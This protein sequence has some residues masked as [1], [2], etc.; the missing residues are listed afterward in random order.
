MKETVISFS[1]HRKLGNKVLA[2]EVFLVTIIRHLIETHDKVTF[3]FGGALGVDTMASEIA[4]KL[5]DE[6]PHKDVQVHLYLPCVGFES[7][8][9][10]RDRQVLY[11]QMEKA[12]FWKYVDQRN[13]IAPYQLMNRNKAMVNDS[14]G[15]VAVWNGSKSGTSNCVQY[16]KQ[17]ARHLLIYNPNTGETR[18]D[19]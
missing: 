2:V 16:A 13:Y 15:T 14:V 17:K 3:I 9:Q 5:R 18:R 19:A 10:E 4:L 12:N 8:W 6:Y 7:V 1:G 11:S